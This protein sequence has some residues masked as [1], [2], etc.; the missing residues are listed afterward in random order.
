MG[1]AKAVFAHVFPVK[2]RPF[3]LWIVTVTTAAYLLLEFSFNSRLLDVVGGN[4]SRSDVDAIEVYGRLISGFALALATW[5]LVFSGALARGWR[6]T[7]T[8]F[9]LTVVSAVLI[10]FA[11]LA[12]K[13]LVDSLVARSSAGDRY[14][15]LNL[16]MLQQAL[17][18]HDL[19]LDNMPFDTG[20]PV[21]PDIK[22]F[23]AIFPLLASPIDDL[24]HK[25]AAQK[26]LVVRSQIDRRYGGLDEA[27]ADYRASLAEIQRRYN[28]DYVPASNRADAASARIGGEQAR[29]WSDYERDLRRHR[30]TPAS[31]PHLYWKRV[32]N[33]VRGKGVPVPN[34]WEPGDRAGFDAAVARKARGNIQASFA[35]GIRQRFPEGAG[36]APYLSW[37]AF[38]NHPAIQSYWKHKLA[39]PDEVHLPS[40]IGDV[41]QYQKLVYTPTLDVR[42]AENLR[43]LDAPV[44]DF[45]DGARY[46]GIGQDGMRAL[47]VPP[48]AL[49]FSLLGALV[50]IFKFLLGVIQLVTQRGF[51]NIV[52]KTAGIVAGALLIF[53]VANVLP[54]TPLTGQKL[55]VDR[56]YPDAQHKYGDASMWLVRGTIHLQPIAYPVFEFV[57]QDV[58]RGITFGVHLNDPVT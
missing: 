44:S 8:V 19:A 52:Y 6:R 27:Y 29:A 57:R 5:P 14:V 54:T 17:V 48:I 13:Q 7:R 36:L 24:D 51:A 20:N 31:V 38:A 4:A 34:D 49:G 42:Q 12:E 9:V 56:L 16:H 41:Q 32:R 55:F 2:G 22:T 23:L 40:D 18:A 45:A 43:Q 58:F 10:A 47:I 37:P 28:D 53:A 25:I 1:A 3:W 26:P 35:D 39:I 21:K 46:A 15:A 33:D 11:Y 50:H 30:L